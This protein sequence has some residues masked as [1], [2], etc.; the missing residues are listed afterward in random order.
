MLKK[1]SFILFL[2]WA[3]ALPM[4]AQSNKKADNRAEVAILGMYHFANPQRDVV[5][6]DV[7]DVLTPANQKDI[8]AIAKKLA[9]FKPTK[10]AV[11]WETHLSDEVNAD[12]RKY[13]AGQ[14]E[15]TR[16]EVH[17]LGFR[18]AKMAGHKQLYLVDVGGSPGDANIGEAI[19][20]AR[21]K[22]PAAFKKFND[23]IAEI[24]AEFEKMHKEYTISQIL[25]YL[26]T[27]EAAH[28]NLGAYIDMAEIGAGD[29]FIGAD[30]TAAWYKRNLRIYANIAKIS[31]PG[32]RILVIFGQGHKPVLEQIA[33]DSEK[34]RI[35]DIRKYL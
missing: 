15:L 9:K 24:T 1:A 34:V 32:D 33:I 20:Y 5:K 27:P 26:N 30:A 31:E 19:D 7:A 12:Y 3:I 21:Q 17:Q 18:L 23:L 28:K 10:I 2:V 14:F 13:V 29:N 8:E 35:A 6:T 4:S 22:D 16:N 25:R 11:E